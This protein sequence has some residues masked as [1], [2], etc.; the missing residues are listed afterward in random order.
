MTVVSPGVV[1]TIPGEH[2]R[3]MGLLLFGAWPAP[4]QGQV[5]LALETGAG[6]HRQG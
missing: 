2:T 1:L 3:A 5:T 6:H 4:L